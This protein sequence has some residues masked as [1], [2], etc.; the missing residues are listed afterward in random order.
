M[1][2]PLLLSI[3]LLA[4]VAGCSKAPSIPVSGAY[5][6]D[7]IFCILAGVLLTCVLRAALSRVR[8]GMPPALPLLVWPALIVLLSLLCWLI[9]FN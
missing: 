1:R 8:S 7:W 2:K 4:S 9:V 6:P 5:F 3:A